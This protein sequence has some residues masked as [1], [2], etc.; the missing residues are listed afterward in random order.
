MKPESRLEFSPLT[1]REFVRVAVLAASGAALGLDAAGQ[2][3]PPAPCPIIVF[4][5]AFQSLGPEDTA[6]L[7]EEVGWSGIE[8]PVREK[9]QIEPEQ[10]ADEMPRYVD[11]LRRRGLDM[12]VVVTEI[13][14]MR[15]PHAETI[16]R[17]AAKLGIKRIRL[18]AWIYAPD[19]PIAQQLDEFG[20]A[21]KDIGEACAEL[22]IQSAV[23]N[24]SGSDRFGAPVWD[25]VGVL[26]D[27]RVRNVGM[28]FDIGHA[29]IEGGLS[30]P[31]QA[32]L[33]EHLYTVVYVKDFKW[34]REAGLWKP[35]WCP[36]GEGM[37]NRSFFSRLRLTGFTGPICQH[38]EYPLG[39]RTEMLGHMRRDLGV[40][41]DWL[42]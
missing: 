7:V 39:D 15:E 38:H 1:R 18:G 42:A 25:D 28:C 23:Q 8:C 6:A 37:I 10:A 33:A 41:K 5:K 31:I 17:T 32:R 13:A 3:G 4:S 12:T 40:L 16:L 9:G 21:L 26:K 22:G 20:G 36:L 30:W 24:H 2:S 29:T 19:R 14:S 35:G 27:H 11:A 34:R